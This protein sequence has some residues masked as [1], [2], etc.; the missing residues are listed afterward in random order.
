MGKG[1][2]ILGKKIKNL[3]TWGWGRI[4]S[5][6]E[7]YTPLHQVP[8]RAAGAGRYREQREE[9]VQSAGGRQVPVQERARGSTG[10]ALLHATLI[11]LSV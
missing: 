11:P 7:L 9:P 4:S 1:T 3:K 5:C 8:G 10:R 2:E 6:R